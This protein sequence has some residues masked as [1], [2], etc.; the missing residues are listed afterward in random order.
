MNGHR[1]NPTI[2]RE[3][4]IRGIV[5]DTLTLD[6][7]VALGRSFG[8]VVARSGGK[9]V[10]IGRDGRLAS[11]ELQDGL[12]SGLNESGIHVVTIGTCPTPALYFAVQELETDGGIMVTGSH[13]PPE[14]NGFK[15]T[16]GT[17]S[18]FGK[19]ISRLGEMAAAGDFTCGRGQTTHETILERYVDRIAADCRFG[20]RHL[21]VAWDSGNGSAGK[22]MEML[23]ARLPGR[24]VLLNTA[25]DG[26]FPA[27]HPDPTVI[28]NLEQ[29]IETVLV[30]QCDL[31]IAF[32]GDGDR[33]GVVDGEGQVLWG[34]QLMT[35]WA[36][37][38]LSENPGAAIMAD[39]KASQVLFDRIHE[40]G[41]VPLMWRTGHSLIKAG[42]S[43]TGALL[44]GEMS[45]H[46]F[47]ADKYFGYDDALY[48]AGRLLSCL[49]RDA[50]TLA[51]MRKTLPQVVNTPEIR[52]PCPEERKFEVV[53]EVRKRLSQSGANV[54][55][56]DGVR[57][58]TR[59]GWWLLRSSNTQAALVARCEAPTIAQLDPLKQELAGQLRASGLEPPMF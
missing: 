49:S 17:G 53:E 27:H 21:A 47:F 52:F 5:G 44:A 34:D 6:D 55:D 42:I 35:V 50:R 13:N 33:I 1:F 15:M 31:G 14:Y 9:T 19:D 25:I 18:F 43:E 23:V 4:D 12:V 16:L 48:A 38:V 26:T 39:V 11:P 37:E 20:D 51:D 57:V 54:C 2:L 32:D 29:L 36:E 41:G 59:N 22:A 30:E 28:A 8:T 58:Q 46:V 40:L 7:S 45:G 24:H 3:Y 10:C 56:I